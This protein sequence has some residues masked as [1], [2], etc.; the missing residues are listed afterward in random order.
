MKLTHTDYR[1]AALLRLEE[2]RRLYDQ[3]LWVGATY[4]AGRAV[5][6]IL[7]SLLALKARPHESGHDLARHLAQVQHAGRLKDNELN[8]L[9]DDVNE[10]AVVWH[11]NLRFAGEGAFIAL[12]KTM[13][14]D[15]RIGDMRVKGDPAKANA[16]YTRDATERIV[17]IGEAI[18]IRWQRNSRQS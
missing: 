18:W 11:N 9:R 16:K 17:H 6:S 2:A 13:K 5:E 15:R 14:R 3:Q 7:R 12:L 10:I 4:L 8:R 1:E